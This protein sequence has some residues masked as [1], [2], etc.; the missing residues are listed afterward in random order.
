MAR[1]CSELRAKMSSGAVLQ[2]DAQADGRR[3]GGRYPAPASKPHPQPLFLI[4]RIKQ[5]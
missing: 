4:H 2:V 5:S 1:N 3:T